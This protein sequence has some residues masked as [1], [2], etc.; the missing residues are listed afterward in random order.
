MEAEYQIPT[1]EAL[2]GRILDLKH[3]ECV[4]TRN[5]VLYFVCLFI[6]LQI[7]CLFVCTFGMSRV[8]F[9]VFGFLC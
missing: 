8:N 1:N 7:T 4:H 6:L 9:F 2:N 5:Q 3:R